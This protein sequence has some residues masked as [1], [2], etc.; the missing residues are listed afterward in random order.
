MHRTL[1]YTRYSDM[2]CYEQGEG[3][4]VVCKSIASTTTIDGGGSGGAVGSDVDFVVEYQLL[5]IY[6][7]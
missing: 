5:G 7:C 1:C 4:V 3:A 2:V 6:S